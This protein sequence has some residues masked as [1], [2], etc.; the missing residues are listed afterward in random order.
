L[1]FDPGFAELFITLTLL[2]LE[3]DINFG[4]SLL[5]AKNGYKSS[6][7]SFLTIAADFW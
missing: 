2:H 1:W 4:V 6:L 5:I 3:E 7:F